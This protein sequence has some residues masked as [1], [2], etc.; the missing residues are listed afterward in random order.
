MCIHLGIVPIPASIPSYSSPY[1]AG[2]FDA[3]GTTG[4]YLKGNGY[5]RPVISVKNK[6]E[7]DVRLFKTTFGGHIN[8]EKGQSFKWIVSSRVDIFAFLKYAEL[9]YFKSFKS[10]KF[11][12][13]EEFYELRDLRAYRPESEHNARWVIH[14][15]KWCRK[16]YDDY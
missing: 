13:F 15:A 6:F 4:V 7:V 10:T 12:L 5:P 3:D 2:F 14:Y 9:G 1:Y 8:E 11:I 16:G